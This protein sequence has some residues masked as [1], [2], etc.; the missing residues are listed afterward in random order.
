MTFDHDDKRG[1]P[2]A[3][4]QAP[5]P[6][7]GKQTL[8]M[9]LPAGDAAHDGAPLPDGLRARASAV[10]G[11]DL[12]GVRVHDDAASARAAGALGARAFARHQDIHFAAGEYRPGT[13]DGDHLLVHE[14]V[15][16]VQQRGAPAMQARRGPGAPAAAGDVGDV[17]DA[18]DAAEA[19]ADRLAGAIVAGDTRRAEVTARPGGTVQRT[20]HVMRPDAAR[21]E[22]TPV[23]ITGR[24]EAIDP[25]GSNRITLE[26]NQ[27]GTH[28]EGWWQRRVQRFASGAHMEHKRIVGDVASSAP[29]RITFHYQRYREGGTPQAGTLTAATAGETIRLSLSE[30]SGAV[31]VLPGGELDIDEW[32]HDFRRTSTAPRLSEAGIESLPAEARPAARAAEDA[33]L[34]SDEE[35]RLRGSA[36]I[37]MR[38]VRDWFDASHGMPRDAYAGGIDHVVETIY[39]QYATEQHVLVTRRLHELLVGPT[40]AGGSITRPYWDWLAVIVATS[41]AYTTH[42][43]S[44]LGFPA[45][46]IAAEAGAPQNQYAWSFEVVGLSGDVGVGLG[47]FL[48]RFRI[49]QTAGSATWSAS[50]FTVLGQ[51]SGGLSEGITVGMR[52][53]NTFQSPFP[54]RSGNFRGAYTITGA[55]AGAAVEG[56]AAGGVGFINFFGD[57][58]FP[59]VSGDAGGMTEIS[60]LYIGAEVSESGGYLFG[61]RD[62]AIAH[63]RA[64]RPRSVS[65]TYGAG[66]EAH[67]A[68]DDPSLTAPG[69]QALRQT[70]ALHRAMLTN[71]SGAISITGYASPAGR[72][73]HNRTLSNLRARNTL[74]AIRDIMGGDLGVPPERQAYEGL[75]EAPARAAGVP[76]GEESDA[77]RKVEVSFNGTVVL[78]LHY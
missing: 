7:V 27:A 30:G 67:F 17:G 8:A 66:T 46:G 1:V 40:F 77:W 18:G 52:T 44:R 69:W 12:S 11:A 37:I 32:N 23:Q 55:A 25:G 70:C 76:D 58:S 72:D 51:V 20:P 24:Y 10:L 16:T 5:A 45:S 57:G 64:S 71:T 56:G 41:P 3:R 63:A 15:H 78:T 75:G 9:Q 54:W 74:Q 29:D 22:H 28:F 13:S 4:A 38:R 6:A 48:G 60:G 73:D 35:R 26:L 53:S 36:D 14:V 65:G 33:P 49:E 62:E 50:Y 59:P 47:G 42:L 34:D 61:G 21:P 68:V 19:E 31:R 39:S 43:Q 2:D